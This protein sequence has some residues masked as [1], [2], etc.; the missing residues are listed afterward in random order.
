MAPNGR[1]QRVAMHM[2][3]TDARSE[4][5]RQAL[6]EQLPD[7]TVE[8]PDDTGTFELAIDADDREAAL[9]RVWD[10]IA[11]AGVDDRIVFMEHPDLPEHWRARAAGRSSS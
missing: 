9:A 8:S 2:L 1:T 11:A 3:R 7:A 6:A 10:A 5:A 4:L